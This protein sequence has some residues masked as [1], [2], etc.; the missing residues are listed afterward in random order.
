MRRRIKAAKE[1]LARWGI[2]SG[3][4][5][6]LRVR[7]DAGVLAAARQ[8]IGI[9]DASELVEGGLALLAAT[10]DFGPWL[11]QQAGRLPEDFELAL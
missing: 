11:L 3:K 2:C 1:E 5:I 7:V 4:R 9:S 6:S 8:A 10:D